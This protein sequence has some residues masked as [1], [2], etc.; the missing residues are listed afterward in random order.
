MTAPSEIVRRL[1]A[2]GCPP[3]AIA[4]ALELIEEARADG[5]AA[6]A[7][8]R[9][10]KRRERER[11]RDTSRDS[12]ATVTGQTVTDTPLS[13]PP[14]VSPTPPS[15]TPPI[16]PPETREANASLSAKAA[17]D[18]PKRSK[19]E[20]TAE[21]VRQ[22]FDDWNA[23]AQR[24]ALPI[25]KDLND[26]RRKAIRARLVDAG[27]EGWTEALAA[28]ERSGHCR[29]ENDRNWRADLDFVCQPK[30]WQRL[31]EGF[32]GAD[33]APLAAA[34]ATPAEWT[35]ARWE[36]AVEIFATSGRWPEGI[37]P[38]PAEPGCKAPAPLLT[39][40]GYA[41]ATIHPFDR[42]LRSAA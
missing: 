16:I 33:K 25:A 31:R 8:A 15:D 4:V 28:V 40:K 10:R 24:L 30:S 37:G 41:G 36:A 22:A 6:K 27:P 26:G 29:G 7:S 2:A 5:D 20:V 35:P 38:N 32:Y 39:A 11:K 9:E 17:D 34:P 13:S 18:G 14:R 3:E 42:D 12:H 23:L 19:P 1:T 21:H